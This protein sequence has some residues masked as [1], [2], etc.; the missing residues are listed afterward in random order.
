MHGTG[1]VQAESQKATQAEAHRERPTGATPSCA[2]ID[3][4]TSRHASSPSPRPRERMD[5]S[6]HGVRRR[7][8]GGHGDAD[9]N[10]V[11]LPPPL[12]PP[13]FPFPR[14]PFPSLFACHVDVSLSRQPTV[15]V[16]PAFTTTSTL[17][18]PAFTTTSSCRC[19]LLPFLPPA[20]LHSCATGSCRCIPVAGGPAVAGSPRPSPPA[21][22][23][24]CHASIMWGYG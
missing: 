3:A 4:T 1:H 20:L 9:G 18:L 11:T 24:R 23:C 22:V 5:V 13:I 2:H 14:P 7:R 12:Y 10:A 17:V 8:G 19:L 15:L 16:L 21:S 6:A